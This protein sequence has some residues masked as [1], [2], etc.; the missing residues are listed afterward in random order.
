[1]CKYDGLDTSTKNSASHG[2]SVLSYV[3]WLVAQKRPL[4]FIGLPGF[5]LVVLGLLLGIHTLQYYNVTHVF[6]VSYAILV[7]ILLIVGVLGMFI[8]LMLNVLPNILKSI[9]KEAN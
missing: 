7:S 4:L 8:G 3:I 1:M 6:L 2:F 5:V 9:Q